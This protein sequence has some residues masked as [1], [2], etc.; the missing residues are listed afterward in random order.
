MLLFILS[1]IWLLQT[2]FGERPNEAIMPH[3]LYQPQLNTGAVPLTPSEG[4]VVR[5]RLKTAK[6]K[7][8]RQFWVKMGHFL[9]LKGQTQI[10]TEKS[11]RVYIASK[12]SSPMKQIMQNENKSHKS[13]K[14]NSN[15]QYFIY[16][17]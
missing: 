8:D 6:A 15:I 1:Q 11:P 7:A 12:I 2:Y 9:P 16:L 14:N 5:G 10:T 3:L 13:L 4:K 17:I